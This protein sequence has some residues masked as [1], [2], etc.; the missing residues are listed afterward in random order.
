MIPSLSEAPSRHVRASDLR[1]GVLNRA[2]S[3][4]QANEPA[5]ALRLARSVWETPGD[6]ATRVQAGWLVCVS[7]YRL[8]ELAEA[9]HAGEG[10]LALLE[11]NASQTLRF[12]ILA[13]LVVA[14]GEL[15]RHD[16]SVQA[17]QQLVRLRTR[18]GTLRD[19]TRARSSMAACFALMGDPWTAQQLLG[20]LADGL[21]ALPRQGR[22]E[23]KA[24]INMAW[25]GLQAARMARDAAD[26][27]LAGRMLA[28][29]RTSL[30]R[31]EEIT[32]QHGHSR[33]A[34][35]SQMHQ[36]EYE[37]L[38]GQH[39]QALERVA[40]ALP[41]TR[42]AHLHA[43]T[44][45]LEL[46]QAEL[47]LETGSARPALDVLEPLL[48]RLG[49]GHDLSARLQAFDLAARACA[50]LGDTTRSLVCME[51]Q[52]ALELYRVTRQLQA[53]SRHA[54]IRLELEHLSLAGPP[55]PRATVAPSSTLEH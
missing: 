15:A 52:R 44:R 13:L 37:L 25:I 12:D 48:L 33:I 30:A 23:A 18:R 19:H 39:A 34:L 41:K 24:R 22:L 53:M 20:Q 16:E 38:S 14:Y 51:R 46:I 11:P 10:A 6:A 47:L 8:G 31:S 29:A 21:R 17:L 45:R 4:H 1:E 55:V 49:P 9:I 27:D 26:P 50:A 40:A 43:H 36:C 42:Q 54:R 32:A 7:S 28:S 2:R 5:V 3:L 35:F